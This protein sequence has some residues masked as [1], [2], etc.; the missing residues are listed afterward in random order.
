MVLYLKIYQ[1]HL[2][3]YLYFQKHHVLNQPQDLIHVD[4]IAKPAT[5]AAVASIINASFSLDIFI[6]LQQVSS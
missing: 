6:Y 2:H 4:I 5:G 1:M 3:L